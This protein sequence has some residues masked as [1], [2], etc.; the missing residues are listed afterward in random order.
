MLYKNIE[1]GNN[2]IYFCEKPN[3]YLDRRL[4]KE[5]KNEMK[6][7]IKIFKT[8]KKYI[9]NLNKKAQEDITEIKRKND[10]IDEYL[11]KKKEKYVKNEL[12]E[13]KEFFD[14][15]DGKK[16]DENQRK[17]VVIN[18]INNQIIAGAGSGK[19]LTLAAKIKYLIDKKGIDAREILCL[20]YSNASKNDLKKKVPDEVEVKTFHGLGNSILKEKDPEVYAFDK[21]F[22]TFILEKEDITEMVVTFFSKYF[23][24][25]VTDAESLGEFYKIEAGRNLETLKSVELKEIYDKEK[26]LNKEEKTTLKNEIVKSTEELIIANFLYLNGVDYVYEISY[27]HEDHYK[28]DFYLTDYDIYLEHFGVDENLDALWIKDEEARQRYK[29]GIYWKREIHEKNNTK[30]IE[31]YSYYSINDKLTENLEEL[32][33]ENGVELNRINVHI[34]L[35]KVMNKRTVKQFNDFKNLFK[36]FINLFKGNNFKKSKFDEFIEESEKEEVLFNKTRTKMFLELASRFYDY[37]EDYLRK[38]SKR[39]MNKDRIDFNDMINLATER[40]NEQG[41]SALEYDYKYLIVDEYQDVSLTRTKLLKAIQDA[42]GAKLTVV[43]D[44]WQSIYRFTGCDISLFTKFEEYYEKPEI[45]KIVNTYRNSQELIDVSGAFIMQNEHQIP[46]K[47]NSQNDSIKK[48]IKIKRYVKKNEVINVF[49]DSIKEISSFSNGNIL[50]LG[51]NGSDIN[52]LKY[53]GEEDREIFE[54]HELGHNHYEIIY[55]PKDY[56]DIEFRTVHSSKGLEADNVIILNLTTEGAGFPS[57]VSNDPILRFVVDETDEYENAEERRLFYVGLTRTRNYTYLFAPYTNES[58]FVTE[59]KDDINVED[60]AKSNDLESLPIIKTNLKCPICETGDVLIRK[61]TNAEGKYYEQF[62]CSNRACEWQ[63]GFYN[64]GISLDTLR[65]CPHC[66]G[67]IYDK[68]GNGAYSTC[69]N[70]PKCQYNPQTGRLRPKQPKETYI[71]PDCGS[72]LILRDGKYGLFFGCDNFPD[73]RF[74][75]GVIE[76]QIYKKE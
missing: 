1:T 27:P 51:R 54:I 23:N 48:P 6:A 31:T 14:D 17:A 36:S 69:S 29:D 28:P 34:F 62:V 25:L 46:K 10:Y 11:E 67:I 73:C 57:N 18:E 4:K 61:D 65:F 9:E 20:T 44:D 55:K 71:C 30:M 21:C 33:L 35:E 66:Q 2:I 13:N 60:D 12:K 45:L 38:T 15:F 74:S 37:Y 42:T 7:I 75:C 26:K 68:M 3:R 59:I 19:S 22:N 16:L 40:V 64:E 39:K 43:G 49:R 63:G 32:L 70:F 76:S 52:F 50:V 5:I 47:L 8:N 41:S 58:V 24:P 72:K 53:M 56:I